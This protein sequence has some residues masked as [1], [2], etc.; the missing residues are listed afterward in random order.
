MVAVKCPVCQVPGFVVEFQGVELDLCPDC[1]GT[2]FD[3]GEL[4]LILD[5]EHPVEQNAAKTEEARRRCPICRKKMDKLNIGPGRSV[6]IDSCPEGCG[7]WF[8]AGEL[9]DLTRNLQDEGWL[10]A[11]EIREYLGSMFSKPDEG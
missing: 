2:W 3:R 9:D 1:N 10:V 6:L 4:D 11:P 8:D 7:L 5:Q